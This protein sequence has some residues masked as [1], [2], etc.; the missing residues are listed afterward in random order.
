MQVVVE[1]PDEFSR[2]IL[3]AGQDPSR[4]LLEEAALKAFCENRVT[5]AELRQ[6]LGFDTRYQV[7]GFLK[8][9]GIDQGAYGP[10]DLEHDVQTMDRL[11]D[12]GSQNSPS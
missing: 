6:I 10:E 1:I 4:A 2:Q 7:D 12:K 11:R 8:E 5:T 3:P 9:R